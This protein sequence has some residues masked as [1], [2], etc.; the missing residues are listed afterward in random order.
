MYVTR[1]TATN[2]FNLLKAITSCK[3]QRKYICHLN[4]TFTYAN[5]RIFLF[6]MWRCAYYFRC[7]TFYGEVMI[8]FSFSSI[9]VL[10]FVFV[11]F[12][13]C[14]EA[15]HLNAYLNE[16]WIACKITFFYHIYCLTISNGI[17]VIWVRYF[18]SNFFIFH[19]DRNSN[20]LLH[21]N[22][23]LNFFFAYKFCVSVC[24]RFSLFILPFFILRE[25]KMHFCHRKNISNGEMNVKSK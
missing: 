15:C 23:E 8:F 17:S 2:I 6:V 18:P 9:S 3:I 4:W 16:S 24:V 25:L 11:V 1:K 10:Y 12:Q 22:R 19:D 21:V 20:F 7:M 13:V 14:S 5:E